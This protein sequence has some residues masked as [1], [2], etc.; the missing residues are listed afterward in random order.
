LTLVSAPG[1]KAA[2]EFKTGLTVSKVWFREIS[3]AK[4]VASSKNIDFSDPVSDT[5]LGQKLFEG[6]ATIMG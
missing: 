2:Q 5:L 4:R 6:L 3:P 1:V